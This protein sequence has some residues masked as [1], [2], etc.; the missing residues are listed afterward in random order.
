MKELKFIC[1]M[2][3]PCPGYKAS[4]EVSN[5]GS[6]RSI[7]RIAGKRRGVVKSK[8]LKPY[9]N[10]RGYLEVRLFKK[11]LSLPRI[12]HRLVAK[13]FTSNN[14]NKPQVNHIDGNK[15]NNELSNLEWVTNSENQVHAY[16]LGLQPSR[17]GEN[18]IK[19]KITD[20]DVTLLKELYNSGKSV[21]EVSNI[22]NISLGLI[23]HIIY[24]RTWKSNTT[25]II[26]RDD[27]FKPTT[28]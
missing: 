11:S 8:I 22:M 13:A 15:L 17:A 19:A 1:E 9:I 5:L 7:D 27:R 10:R 26:R 12:I 4:Y 24:G 16:R 3:R 18:N 28:L 21:V 14:F 25:I 2:W 20:K 6:V 23:R